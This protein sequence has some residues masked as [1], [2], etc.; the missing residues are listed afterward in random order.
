L[1]VE[2]FKQEFSTLGQKFLEGFK[3]Q[4]FMTMKLRSVFDDSFEKSIDF[5]LEVGVGLVLVRVELHL[6]GVELFQDVFSDFIVGGLDILGSGIF[7]LFL[8]SLL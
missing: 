4:E 8:D 6:D 2:A 7:N 5:K 1:L 3:F